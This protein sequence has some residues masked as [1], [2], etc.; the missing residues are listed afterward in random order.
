MVIPVI[1]AWIFPFLSWTRRWATYLSEYRSI[2]LM[3]GLK[4]LNKL[5]FAALGKFY[6]S[7]NKVK[8]AYNETSLRK[9]LKIVYLQWK[10]GL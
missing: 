5:Y 4:T 7:N 8:C 1:I 2:S 6:L 9:I 10:K 3:K